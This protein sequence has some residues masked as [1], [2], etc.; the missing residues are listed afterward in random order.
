MSK[1]KKILLISIA[2]LIVAIVAGCIAYFSKVGW[3]GQQQVSNSDMVDIVYDFYGKWLKAAQSTTTDPYQL[4]LNKWP[5]LGKELRKRLEVKPEG[6]DPVLCQTVIPQ[7][8]ATR[9]VFEVADKAQVLV[10]ARKPSTSTEQAIVTLLKHN[11][12]W[13]MSDIVCSPGEFAPKVEFTFDQTGELTKSKDHTINPQ[14]WQLVFMQSALPEKSYTSLLFGP[15]SMCQS[16]DGSTAVCKPA[17]FT[18]GAKAHVQGQMTESGAEVSR[19]EFV[20]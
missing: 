3:P 9:N 1:N 20:Q 10:N 8:I 2:V 6:I 5:Y 7:K 19:V 12:G 16:L 4:G 15:Q 14:E 18:E 17:S 11:G 13:Y